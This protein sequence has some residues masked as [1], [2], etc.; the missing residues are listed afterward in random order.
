MIIWAIA[1]VLAA[2]MAFAG[3]CF[4]VIRA[5]FTFFGLL[6]ALL[7]ARI[8]A[9]GLTPQL[10]HLGVKNPIYAWLLAPLIVFIIALTVVKVIGFTVQRKINLHYKYKTGDLKLGLWTRLNTRLGIAVGL[11]NALIYLIL[12]T[13]IIYPLSYATTEL[14]S[15]DS[16]TWSTKLMNELGRELD[17]SG[18]N[19]VALAV[20]PM[21]DT[22]YK[23]IDLAGLIYHND[24]L[25]ARLSRY[26]AFL[27]LA[28]RPEF[29][30]ISNDKDFA[31]LRQKQP[32]ISQILDYPKLQTITG[33][34]DE[35]REIWGLVINNYN[36]I[37]NFLWTGLSQKYADQKLV[38]HWEF[39]INATI[40]AYQVANPNATSHEM[41]AAKQVLMLLFGKANLLATLPPESE[42]FMKD[43]GKI[44][45]TP[46]TPG[47]ANNM[48]Q[49]PPGGGRGG[50]RGLVNGGRGGRGGPQNPAAAAGVAGM[51]IGVDMQPPMQGKWSEDGSSS[52][53]F[54]VNGGD[55]NATVDG[56]TLTLTGFQFPLTF[57]R[58]Y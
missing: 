28:E 36:D 47:A 55:Y 31:E 35:L 48:M 26:P 50:A 21:P 7:C 53:K 5:T 1:L 54:N 10:T 56:D 15:D 38:G 37:T 23:G 17:A 18:L 33:N 9:H 32:P 14:S 24:L 11:G 41:A 44:K 27:A 52:Y 43:F 29:Q 51:T 57:D 20:D 3:Y 58:A 46:T 13:V 30:D 19:K 40:T 22:F 49:Q 2:C 42:L 4:G 6:I 16:A 34:P 8:F 39:N 25:E 12:L 45:Y